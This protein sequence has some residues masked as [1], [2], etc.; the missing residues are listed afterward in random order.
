EHSEND[1]EQRKTSQNPACFPE[2]LEAHKTTLFWEPKNGWSR[3]QNRPSKRFSL[4]HN[5]MGSA[6]PFRSISSVNNSRRTTR[7]FV[8]SKPFSAI[9]F[10]WGVWP[11][12]YGAS[13]R[14]NSGR[15]SWYRNRLHSKIRRGTDRQARRS[16]SSPKTAGNVYWGSG[17]TRIAS[18][19]IR[20]S[21]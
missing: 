16:R 15:K 17:R 1:R 2:G 3:R 7:L 21:R 8:V 6:A 14:G 11:P 18:P 4:N 5:I 19:G 10:I 12:F 9:L 13:S 20:S